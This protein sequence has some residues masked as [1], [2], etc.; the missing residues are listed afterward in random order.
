MSI[1]ANAAERAAKHNEQLFKTAQ[2]AIPG[3]VNSFSRAIDPPI[4]VQKAEGAYLYDAE[5]RRYLD[6][7]AAFGPII[8]GHCHPAVNR[9]VIDAI[10][11]IDLVGIGVT[12]LETELAELVQKY[13]PSADLV[14]FCNTGTEATYNAVRLARAVTGR[15]KLLKF[16]GCF[17]GSHDYLAM[18]VI[19]PRE[20]V[21]TK[22]PLS[23]GTLAEAI[24]HTIVA[25]FNNL[26]EVESIVAKQADD[27]AAI[28][29]EPIPH[30]IGCVMPKQEFLEGL[31]TITKQ[32]GIVLIFD[33]VITGFRHDLGGYQRICGVTPDLT[34]FGKAMA[35]GFSCAA[36]CGR[37][38]LM[39]NFATGGGK[40]LFAGTYNGHPVGMAAGIA[41]VVELEKKQT[42]A[43]MFRLGD[44]VREGLREIF[45]RLGVPN[46]I[47]GFGTIFTAYFME[48]PV[49]SY[50]DLLRNNNNLDV[51]F[52]R[53]LV[54]RGVL[55]HPTPLKRNHICAAHTDADIDFTLENAEAA[56]RTVL[57]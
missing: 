11:R 28:I 13:V 41:T 48:G 38:D 21:G 16:Q 57:Q 55:V 14:H 26:E 50:T 56:L 36:V 2:K 15:T 53:E 40:A 45:H 6:Y 7:H 33:E 43:H 37:R 47:A 19:S 8:L 4:V 46:H 30:N 32:N 51:A 9:A 24:D 31:R 17:H 52:R 49:N 44:R 1:T 18:N 23:A 34:T 54:R 27:I 22:D 25:E 42:Y 35:N 20:K 5:G 3:G 29:L 39:N 10:Q 12:E